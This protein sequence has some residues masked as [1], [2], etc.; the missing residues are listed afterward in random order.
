MQKKYRFAFSEDWSF[1]NGE[2]LKNKIFNFLNELTD[3]TM[4]L[5]DR[6]GLRDSK[7][8]R[9]AHEALVIAFYM[10]D[11]RTNQALDIIENFEL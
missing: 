11:G 6:E 4:E 7:S 8:A 1:D 5:T 3:K 9:K 2:E 10:L